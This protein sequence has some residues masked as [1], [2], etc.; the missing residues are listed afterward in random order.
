MKKNLIE[1]IIIY[2]NIILYLTV[3][4]YKHITWYIPKYNNDNID[5]LL[6]ASEMIELQILGHSPPRTSQLEVTPQTGLSGILLGF[7]L[8]Y[9]GKI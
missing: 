5:T 1:S 2:V 6:D 9:T 3:K 7:G 8:K 4:R